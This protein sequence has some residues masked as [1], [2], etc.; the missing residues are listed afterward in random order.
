MPLDK[1]RN[2]M[3]ALKAG[4]T[5]QKGKYT[6]SR[7]LGAGTFGIT[8]MANTRVQMNGPLG[9]MDVMVDVAVKEFYMKDINVR[10]SDGANIEGTQNA[11]VKDYRHKFRKEAENLAK[12]HHKNIVQVVDV[13]VVC[14]Y[15]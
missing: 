15:C 11:L 3:N 7:V 12:L 8:Y 10:T 4:M 1:K 9:Q 13:F 2:N 5:L 6:I 14:L